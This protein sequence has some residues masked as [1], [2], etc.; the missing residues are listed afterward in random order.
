MLKDCF[1]RRII[2]WLSATAVAVALLSGY[3]LAVASGGEV[4]KGGQPCPAAVRCEPDGD[5]PGGDT[6]VHEDKPGESK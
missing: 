6:G 3:Q 5:R 2:T 4:G 1:M